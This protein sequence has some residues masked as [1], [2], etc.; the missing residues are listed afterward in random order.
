MA[1]LILQAGDDHVARLAHESD[2]LRA[3]VELVW[4]AIDA[5]AS[6][7]SVLFE[8]DDWDAITKTV[9]SDDGHGISVDEIEGTF[10]RIGDSWKRMA[11]TT[12][13]GRRGL[14]GKLGEGRLR[15]FALGSRVSWVSLSL[16]T[17]GTRH[18][19]EIRG[20][21]ARR[22]HFP[23]EA[24]ALDD[25]P[26]GTVVTAWNDSQKSLGALESASA[27]GLL[28]AQFAPVLLAEKDLRIQYNDKLLD[29]QNDVAD[30][31]TLDVR[32]GEGPDVN[33]AE[34]HII[35]WRSAKHRAIHFGRD[36]SH[37][38][39]EESTKDLEPSFNYS[40][41]VSWI[42]L[43]DE[44][45]AQLSLGELA[46]GDA[47]LLMQASRKAIREHFAR[48]RLDRRREQVAKWKAD[49]V[50]PY[51][52]EPTSDAERAERAVFDV[53]SGAISGQISS[54]R[55]NARLT[56]TLLRDAL[57]TDPDRLT[58]ILH[59]VVALNE[60][61]RAALT[62]LL[63]ETTLPAVIRAA[64]LVADRHKF[65]VGLEHLLF[66]PE[67]ARVVGERDHLHR[68]LERE[69]WIFGEGYNVM[70]SERG[71]TEMLRTHLRL[72]GLPTKAV[73]PVRRWDGRT[74][75]LDLHLAVRTQEFDRSRHLVVE[76]KAPDIM[77]GRRELDQVE[78][79]AN[80][81]LS[82]A[83]FA[84]DR[85]DW[86]FILV[87]IDYD[88][89]VANRIEDES[90][91]RGKFLGPAPKPG[92]PR[93]RAY[94]RRWR[95]MLNENQRRLRFVADALEHDPTLAEGLGYIR[96]QYRELLPLALS[97]ATEAEA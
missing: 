86:D 66:D 94:V 51:D 40:A 79:Y 26:L 46:V 73:E 61:D 31:S 2:P 20:T 23:W 70:T 78:D 90:L 65:L 68:L 39:H 64:N 89:V 63:G 9:V 33:T 95:D 27:E 84:S 29:P 85:A 30:Q 28:L 91:D 22:Q 32:F 43:T 82:N 16:D 13:Y 74:G 96:E 4:N 41:Y 1:E 55:S 19:V 58:T 69:L 48:R 93:V 3:V 42:G 49:S 6:N 38:V 83:A 45:A 25:G 10:G 11:S 97:R 57:R 18:R 50:Y 75:R 56:L 15:V 60:H 36:G 14:H 76:L 59:E 87:G 52:T 17:A 12:K 21:T 8:R 7:I 81:V 44:L 72:E 35:E 80:V 62:Q 88:D 92:R 77:L 54:K 34:L 5:E 47:A 37:F 67:A 24:E 53:V 71:L